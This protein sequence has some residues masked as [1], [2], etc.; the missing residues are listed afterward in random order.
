MSGLAIKSASE[1]D[2]A[3]NAEISVGPASDPSAWDLYVDRHEVGGFFHRYGWGEVARAVYG[4]EPIYLEARRGEEIVGVLPLIDAQTPLLGRSL[5]STAFTVG[6]GPIGDS[7]EVIE[8]LAQAAV[9]AG[10]TRN[11]QYVELRSDAPVGEGWVAKTG[12]YAGFQM[13]LP[14]DPDRI[15][16]AIPRKRRAEIRKA[17]K[18]NEE[19]AIVLKVEPDPD[20]FYSLYAQ[21]LRDHGTPIFPKAFLLKIAEVFG[22]QCEFRFVEHQGKAAAGLLNFYHQDKV[23]PYY[24]GAA[25]EARGLRAFE[26][27][28]WSSMRDA[29]QKGVKQFDFGRSKIGT[30]PYH[31]KKLWGIEPELLTY[32]YKLIKAGELPDVNPNNPKFHIFTKVWKYLPLPVANMAGPVLARNFP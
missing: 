17:I 1:I 28:Y 19:G 4:Y 3:S 18:A 8:A 24:V 14:E 13:Q 21:S 7:P 9:S 20:R 27:L 29:A 16:N 32:K 11:V 15:L 26:F 5:I 23:L 31:F 22:A 30:G 12:K 10:Q 6:G 2:A 25:K